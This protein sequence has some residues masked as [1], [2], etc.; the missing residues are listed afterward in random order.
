MTALGNFNRE[1]LDPSLKCEDTHK[2]YTK[3]KGK[4]IGQDEA[5]E[6]AAS[7]IQTFKAGFNQKGKPLAVVMYLGPTGTGKTLTVESVAECLFGN[8][9]AF[10][11]MDCAEFQTPSSVATLLGASPGYIGFKQS[12]PFISQEKL[13]RY[14][15]K[16]FP[17]NIM[18]LDEVEKAHES[19]IQL[20]LGVLD[21]ATLKTNTGEQIDFSNTIIF[22]TSNLGA[23][24]ISDAD[25]SGLGFVNKSSKKTED[26]V[27]KAAISA[28]EKFFSREFANRLDHVIVFNS[29]TQTSI[30]KILDLEL[31]SVRKRIFAAKAVSKF[32]FI[33]TKSVE[34]FILSKGYNPRYGA[35]ELRRIIS[36]YVTDPLA[37]LM[38]SSQV[39]F[40]DLV[41]L[42]VK[43]GNVCY[44]KIDSE[45]IYK[46]SAEEWEEFKE[47]ILDCDVEGES[48][49]MLVTGAS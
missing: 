13:N 45:T 38:M 44:E 7:I 4:V 8:S 41:I 28:M 15:T 19:V 39:C 42:S 10:F 37:S 29:L 12:E 32:T 30:K 24:E 17:I 6:K 14:Q 3:L 26:A 40:G 16:E 31:L 25:K 18:L 35:R 5:L 47:Q 9:K 1:T 27:K 49:G 20:F 48:N 22:M 34:E 23:V 46:Y 11:K 21:K 36:K 43:D 2:F 33:C